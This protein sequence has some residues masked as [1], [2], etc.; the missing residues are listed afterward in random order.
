MNDHSE[1]HHFPGFRCYAKFH[2]KRRVTRKRGRCVEPDSANSEQ[3]AFITIWWERWTERERRRKKSA[4][5]PYN[6]VPPSKRLQTDWIWM[7]KFSELKKK[8]NAWVLKC[9]VFQRHSHC[10]YDFVSKLDRKLFL[11]LYFKLRM[12]KTFCC[13]N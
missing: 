7:E 13:N 1:Y 12:L 9:T 8:K 11:F 6:P 4:S 5:W 10:T 3:G 2:R